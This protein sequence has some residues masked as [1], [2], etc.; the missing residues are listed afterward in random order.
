[1]FLFLNYKRRF[2][3]VAITNGKSIYGEAGRRSSGV[4]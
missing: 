1:M 4:V 3:P 2:V